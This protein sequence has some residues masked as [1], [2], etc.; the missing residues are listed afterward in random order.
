MYEN[1]FWSSNNL[2]V[3]L[4]KTLEK[5][6]YNSISDENN[7]NNLKED[8]IN[9]DEENIKI[10]EDDIKKQISKLDITI[11]EQQKRY[12]EI[13]NANKSNN[14]GLSD[15]LISSKEQISPALMQTCKLLFK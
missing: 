2:I 11:K 9:E 4:N 14:G 10:D 13:L 12:S 15:V 3:N 7:N 6:N 5:A 8:L 1:D